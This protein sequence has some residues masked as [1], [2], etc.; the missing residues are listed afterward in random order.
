MPFDWDN[1]LGLAVS[2]GDSTRG[3][4]DIGRN[5]ALRRTAISRAYYAVYHYA[6]NYAI[7][8]LAHNPEGGNKHGSLITCYKR[9]RGSVDLQEVGALLY[10]LRGSRVDCDYKPDDLGNLDALVVSTLGNANRIK[11]LISNIH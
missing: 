11:E 2:I 3:K 4:P 5:E 6:E 1:Y 7:S 9:Q 10:A 8:R